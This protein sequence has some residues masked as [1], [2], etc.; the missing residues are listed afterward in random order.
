MYLKPKRTKFNKSHK[1][2]V[3]Y[4]PLYNKNKE[5]RARKDSQFNYHF[6]LEIGRAH[7]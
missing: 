3:S 5:L 6:A 4:V 2:R 7:V 1:G